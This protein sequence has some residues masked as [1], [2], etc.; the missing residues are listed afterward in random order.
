MAQVGAILVALQLWQQR[1]TGNK[2]ETVGETCRQ[3][4]QDWVGKVSLSTACSDMT[5]IFILPNSVACF[6]W[7]STARAQTCKRSAQRCR[8]Q[9]GQQRHGGHS[10]ES[11]SGACTANKC[12]SKYVTCGNVNTHPSTVTCRRVLCIAACRAALTL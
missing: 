9:R 3:Q 1:K 7:P 8:Q 6:Q 5:I 4:I 2:A 10:L 11:R 12:R